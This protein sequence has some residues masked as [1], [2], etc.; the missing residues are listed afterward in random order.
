M[1]KTKLAFVALMLTGVSTAGMAATRTVTLVVPGMTCP[2]C[3]ITIKKSLEKVSGVSAIASDV[4]QKTVTV[5]YDDAKT[6]PAK[7]TQA[8]ADAG[9][10]STVQGVVHESH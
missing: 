4:A 7:L 6:Q 3:P 9:Y 10:P 2:T 8:T 5:T 1:K